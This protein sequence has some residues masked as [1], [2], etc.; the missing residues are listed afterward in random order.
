MNGRLKKFG[1][2]M[3]CLLGTPKSVF[4]EKVRSAG[5]PI[6]NPGYTHDVMDCWK[7]VPDSSIR[8]NS[9]DEVPVEIVSPPIKG[10]EGVKQLKKICKILAECN[11]TVNK[12]CGLH[13]HVD[14][15]S[16]HVT[17][18]ELCYLYK[19]Y[20][21]YEEVID[22]MM[23]PSRRG[24]NN[25]MCKSIRH[26]STAFKTYN[27]PTSG[28]ALQRYVHGRYYKI[29]CMA[30]TRYGT[31]EFRHHS[32]TTEF[33]KVMNWVRVLQAMLRRAQDVAKQN[34]NFNVDNSLPSFI[35]EIE[36]YT[37]EK[38]TNYVLRRI[39]KFQNQ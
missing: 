17:L 24:S 32:G 36:P 37:D 25:G 14:F 28:E 9:M 31:V 8:R 7:I 35:N 27:P 34:G 22:M 33:T 2:E 39:R 20:A 13:I 12:S 15:Y 30:Y 16:N 18:K 38:V 6:T 5:V 26:I 29:N 19:L 23:P 21:Q 3:E 10:R 4:M 1:V 11:A